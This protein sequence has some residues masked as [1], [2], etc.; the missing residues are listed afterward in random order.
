MYSRKEESRK[1][2]ARKLGERI[3]LEVETT[4]QPD[5]ARD[6]LEFMLTPAFQSVIPTTNWM[7]PAALPADALPEGFETLIQPD[8]GLIFAP[9]EAADARDE[10]LEE[11]RAALSR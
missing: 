4:D 6:F 2:F 7:Y 11:W 5:L 9:D 3:G 10:A 8:V 1:E